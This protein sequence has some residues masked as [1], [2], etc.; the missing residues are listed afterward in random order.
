MWGTTE[1]QRQRGGSGGG[2]VGPGRIGGSLSRY[3]IN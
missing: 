1:S 3:R 2:G